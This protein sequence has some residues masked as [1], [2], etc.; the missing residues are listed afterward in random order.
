MI[1]E[2]HIC[3][4]LNLWLECKFK[5]IHLQNLQTIIKGCL[6]YQPTRRISTS[7]AS[8]HCC[9]KQVPQHFS[10]ISRKLYDAKGIKTFTEFLSKVFHSLFFLWNKS[11]KCACGE[12]RTFRYHKGKPILSDEQWNVLFQEVAEDVS[13]CR[14]IPGL[15]VDN[16]SLDVTLTACILT[17]I[18]KNELSEDILN[19]VITLRGNRNSVSHRSSAK[20]SDADF[21]SMWTNTEHAIMVLAKTIPEQAYKEIRG[22]G[23]EHSVQIYRW[24]GM[25]AICHATSTF[26]SG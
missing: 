1:N 14:F 6:N 21:N 13:K 11:P 19:A 15:D 26:H 24:K 7:T 8:Y 10:L 20:I 2:S 22:N 18:F 12:E 3:K 23:A 5:S 4:E 16:K 9:L 17:N 25:H